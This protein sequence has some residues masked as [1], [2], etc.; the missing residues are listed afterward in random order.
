VRRRISLHFEERISK[1][2]KELLNNIV[3]GIVVY[4]YLEVFE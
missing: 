2:S 3:N 1:I 4:G